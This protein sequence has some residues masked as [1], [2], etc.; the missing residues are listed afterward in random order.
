MKVRCLLDRGTYKYIAGTA[1]QKG[2]TP[3][4]LPAAGSKIAASGAKTPNAKAPVDMR[5]AP[6]TQP[7]PGGLAGS[8]ANVGVNALLNVKKR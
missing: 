4:A 8:L 1:T 3:S 5:T 2:R 6:G 7:I